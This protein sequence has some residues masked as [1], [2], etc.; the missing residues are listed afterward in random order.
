MQGFVEDF[1]E[2]VKIHLY[3]QEGYLIKYNDDFYTYNPMVP[4]VHEW[5]GTYKDTAR[6]LCGYF[7]LITEPDVCLAILKGFFQILAG[8]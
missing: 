8:V 1:M 2:D 3:D 6:E 7:T 5:R 4:S